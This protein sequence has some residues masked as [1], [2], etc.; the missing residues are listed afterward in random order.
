MKSLLEVLPA[1][2]LKRIRV[3]IGRDSQNPRDYVL[4]SF[5]PQELQVL[6]PSLEKVCDLIDE[7]IHGDFNTVLNAYSIWKKSCS[8]EQNPGN[9][10]PK[11]NSNDQEL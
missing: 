6:Q 2:D 4:D 3:G 1:E 9:K 7:Y 10:S 11:E 5:S 8:R